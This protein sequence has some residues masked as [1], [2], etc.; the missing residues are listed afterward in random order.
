MCWIVLL[1]HIHT[2]MHTHRHTDKARTHIHQTNTSAYIAETYTHTHVPLDIQWLDLLWQWDDTQ[3]MFLW[4]T[5]TPKR[6]A[7]PSMPCYWL[8]PATCEAPS[9]FLPQQLN[10]V[11]N[12]LLWVNAYKK[13]VLMINVDSWW[14][15]GDRFSIRPLSS[16]SWGT[17][18]TMTSCVQ[19]VHYC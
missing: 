19:A 10:G 5:L 14:V 3:T 16:T 15:C 2:C 18:Y 4:L 9:V 6:S 11:W 12:A 17:K 8:P 7:H 1:L 13:E